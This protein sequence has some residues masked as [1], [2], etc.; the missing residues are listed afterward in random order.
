VSIDD[1]G[2]GFTSLAYLSRLAVGELKVDRALITRLASG[3]KQDDVELVR[4]TIALGH[5]LRL[6]VVAEGIEDKATLDLV[7]ELGCDLG[8]GYFIGRPKPAHELAF[9]PS[10]LDTPVAAVA[11]SNGERRP[12]QLTPT[13]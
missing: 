6:S 7:S 4:A 5:A 11:S 10:P 13:A 9:G 12:R 8:Q 3:N 2:A 1:F